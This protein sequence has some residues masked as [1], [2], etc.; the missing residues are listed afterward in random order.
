MAAPEE[1]PPKGAPDWIVTFT[2]LVSLLVAFFVLLMT[3]SSLNTNDAFVVHGNLLGT[4][5]AIESRGGLSAVDPPEFDLMQAMDA[6]R[7]ADQPHTRPTEKLAENLEEMGQKKDEQHVEFDLKAVKDGIVLHFEEAA[8]F[9]P[10][11]AEVN[12]ELR[13]SLVEIAQ[14][15][16]HYTHM[17][18]VEGFTDNA[19]QPTPEFESE[20]AL[21][22]ARAAAAAQVMLEESDLSPKLVQLA[23]LGQAKALNENETPVQRRANRRVELRILSLSRAREKE[24]ES[25]RGTQEDR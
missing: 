13:K 16:H 6:S 19:F 22:F 21:S 9:A 12:D 25:S 18:T 3:F 7:G 23:G 14:V 4:S 15:L 17:V 24:I 5:G 8:C 11:S 1:E 10:G 20:E 2:D